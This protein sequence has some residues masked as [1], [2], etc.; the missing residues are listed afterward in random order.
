MEDPNAKTCLFVGDLSSTVTEEDLFQVFESFGRVKHVRIQMLKDQRFGQKTPAGYGFVKMQTAMQAMLALNE[1][2]GIEVKGRKIRV[3]YATY[4]TPDSVKEESKVS[5]YLK[6]VATTPTATSNE[7]L[8]RQV[9]SQFGVLDD[10][11]IRKQF[12][13]TVSKKEIFSLISVQLI[14]IKREILML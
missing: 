13:N 12:V 11:T 3:R 2:N 8:I 10:V 14:L 7:E 1:L 5:L 9:Y 4:H 6:F